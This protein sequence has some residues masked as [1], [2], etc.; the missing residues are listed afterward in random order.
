MG[1]VDV[2]V[3]G[4][5]GFIG[6]HLV[7][8]LVKAGYSVRVLDNLSTGSLDNIGDLISSVEFVK[9]DVRDFN[10]VKEAARGVDAVVHLAALV[11]VA[12]SFEKPDLYFEVNVKGTY[13]VVRACRGVRVLVYASSCAVYGEPSRVPTPEDHPT[14]PNS[15]YALSKVYGEALVE[16]LAEKRGYRPV[17][18]RFFNVYGPG[19]SRAYAG[20]VLEFVK[21]VSRGEPPVIYGDGSQTR[22]FIHVRDAVKAVLKAL[23]NEGAKGVFNVGSGVSVSINELAKLVLKLAGREDLK[24]VY[25]PPR[26]GDVKRSQA[27]ISRARRVLGFEPRVKLEDGIRELLALKPS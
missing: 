12:E 6:G 19:Q 4:G 20:V 18:L 1:R 15:P 16:A 14:S 11:D 10:V 25:A 27:D 23:V 21:R 9:G 8:A 26:P 13:N 2:L 17:V 5:A 24:P 7:R 22:D 3:T